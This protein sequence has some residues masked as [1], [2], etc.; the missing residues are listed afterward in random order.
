ML[1]YENAVLGVYYTL[2]FLFFLIFALMARVCEICERGALRGNTRSHSNRPTR[3]HRQVNLQY[4][5]F[6]GKRTKACASCIRTL[7]KRLEAAG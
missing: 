7:A 5:L 4:T 2:F 1:E 3:K 6:E